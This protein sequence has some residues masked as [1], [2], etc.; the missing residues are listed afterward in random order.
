MNSSPEGILERA[1]NIKSEPSGGI[2][3]VQ[4]MADLEERGEAGVFFLG[5]PRAG[6]STF[7]SAFITRMRQRSPVPLTVDFLQHERT[8]ART[9]SELF[10]HSFYR[11]VM[12]GMRM[13]GDIFP[14]SLW[15]EDEYRIY[16][17]NLEEDILVQEAR[18]VPLPGQRI[19]R[20]AE[21]F[22]VNPENAIDKIVASL[23]PIDHP[24]YDR[25]LSAVK[26]YVA[27]MEQRGRFNTRFRALVPDP[28]GLGR[29]NLAQQVAEESTP[30][31]VKRNLRE[32]AKLI[33]V[34]IGDSEEEGE[35]IIETISNWASPTRAADVYEEFDGDVLDWT[36]GNYDLVKAVKLPTVSQRVLHRW[37]QDLYRR[38]AAYMETH[39]LRERIGVPEE[40]GE[41]L[42]SPIDP[43][44]PIPWD[45]S[46]FVA[47]RRAA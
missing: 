32:K 45:I 43:D 14:R 42:L 44:E 4:T 21:L 26:N 35:L 7:I 19:L 9:E 10:Q 24:P 1:T 6:K 8:L 17:H 23:R 22:S 28:Q 2:L 33:V 20:V 27:L 29:G 25:G 31:E 11:Q 30:A 15:E 36:V 46:S 13:G 3:V 47:D 12:R 5:V 38:R 34:G 40:Y 39:I 37:Q 41:A 18:C 16:S